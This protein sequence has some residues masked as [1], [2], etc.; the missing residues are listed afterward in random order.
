MAEPVTTQDASSPAVRPRV[1]ARLK[2]K[3]LE[4]ATG[5]G[6]ETIRFYVRAGLLPEP[7]RVARNVA[8]YDASFVDRIRLIKQLQQKRFLPLRVIKAIVEGDTALAPAEVQTLA[9]LDAH[10]FRAAGIDRRRPPVKLTEVAQSTGVAPGAIRQLA[11]AGAVEIVFRKGAQWLDDAGVRIV[12][13]Y[14]QLQAA[15]FTEA[16]GFGPENMRLYAEM[17]GWMTREELRRFTRGVAGRTSAEE[18][19]RMIEAAAAIVN[20]IIGVLHASA[21]L[22][23]IA[24]GRAPAAPQGPEPPKAQARQR[25]KKPLT[26][27]RRHM[28]PESTA[29]WQTETSELN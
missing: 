19:S 9:D 29:S 28:R 17:V 4:R 24:S 6:R 11:K 18:K 1:P 26:A 20:Q 8:W 10:L 23:S 21:I 5:V 27:T 3:A 15:G 25:V 12:E 13:L 2:M 16:V 22:R 7:H 14:A